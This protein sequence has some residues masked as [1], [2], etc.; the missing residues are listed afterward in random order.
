MS[1]TKL[2]AADEENSFTVINGTNSDGKWRNWV[3]GFNIE[4]RRFKVPDD[5]NIPIATIKPINVGR[6]LRT[7]LKPS[8]AP[9]VNS[10]NHPPGKK[11]MCKYKNLIN[12]YILQN[13]PFPFYKK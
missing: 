13:F 4:D 1:K 8:S 12:I 5:L 2:V 6:I 3:T 10:L 9:F 7:T 11:L